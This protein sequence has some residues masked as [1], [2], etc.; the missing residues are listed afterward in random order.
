MTGHDEHEDPLNFPA[1]IAELSA[2]YPRR[3]DAEWDALAAGIMKAA[4]P[5]LER[6]RDER[7]FVRSILRLARPVTVAAAAVLLSGA[8][9]LAITS[10]AE[11]TVAPATAPT[12][13]EVVDREPASMLLTV[14]RP[15]SANDLESALDP[16][17][18]PQVQP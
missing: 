7:G 13:A 9:G 12:F 1:P 2:L 6:R 11:A 16:D 17:S 18:F 5:E 3:P 10:D 14:E 15:P 8:I 4:L